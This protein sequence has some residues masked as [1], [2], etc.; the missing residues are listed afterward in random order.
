MSHSINV[1][2]NEH[3][4]NARVQLNNGYEAAKTGLIR[5]CDDAYDFVSEKSAGLAERVHNIATQAFNHALFVSAATFAFSYSP[6]F[7][8]GFAARLLVPDNLVE[9]LKEDN[10]YV[11]TAADYAKDS[12]LLYGAYK[13][14]Q[15]VY[16][17]TSN[18]FSKLCRNSNVASKPPG[19]IA[20]FVSNS[21]GN[22]ISGIAGVT[23]A[24][25]FTKRLRMDDYNTSDWGTIINRVGLAS[26]V[27]INPAVAIAM[28]MIGT[29]NPSP[30][31]AHVV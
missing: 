11:T 21:L 3:V 9:S 24:D 16:R 1:N 25:E 18:F 19:R 10:A 14:S 28:F 15:K 12:V 8:A 23:L 30:E 2:F 5:R 31:R 6:V 27:L 26:G 20:G 7:A 17:S 22:C 4:Q 13:I 29:Q